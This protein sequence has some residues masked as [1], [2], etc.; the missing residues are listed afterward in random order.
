MKSNTH[1]WFKR[2]K[3]KSVGKLRTEENFLLLTKDVSKI[4]W[5]Q[6]STNIILNDEM[7]NTFSLRLG[8]RKNYSLSPVLVY[9]ME[10]GGIKVL[11]TK[12]TS[13]K[14]I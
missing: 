11:T 14:C 4:T 6:H 9:I 2:Q 10:P 5:N 12:K 8:M 1:S 3:Q 7:S 13:L